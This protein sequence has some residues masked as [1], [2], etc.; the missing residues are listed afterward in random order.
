[1]SKLSLLRF[2]L[3]ALLTMAA[4]FANAADPILKV[5]LLGTGG[6][7]YSERMGYS[8]LIEV[9]GQ[10]LLFDVGRGSTQRLY[11]SR[12]NPKDV[13]AVF[14]THL[15]ND[16]YE[17]LPNLWLTPWFLLS[18]K[19][20]IELW[21]P[22]GS[23]EMVVGM[24]KMF[25]HDLD[26]RSNPI[27]KR[28]QLDITVHEITEGVVYER[29]DVKVTAF[30]VEHF[31][32]NPAF[33][34]R[35]DFRN[36][37]VVL[38]GDTTYNENVVKYGTGAD[39]LVHNVIAYADSLKTLPSFKPVTA[40]L[41]TPEQAAEVFNKTKPK[42]AAFSHIAK[43]GLSGAKGDKVILALTRKAGYEGPLLMG[44]DRTVIEIADTVKVLPPA[45]IADLPDLDR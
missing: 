36:H 16:H 37:S 35:V 18:R 43:K 6:P 8:T 5:T 41:T 42:L 17:G 31:D 29:Q 11:E 45:P 13:T 40:K 30:A 4:A 33:G 38:S 34:Y 26:H 21:G 19:E 7:E 24:R 10:K 44:R 2:V 27:F 25:Q 14:L 23:A 22:P 12:I 20:Q 1:M 3:G 9:N 39:L 15:H 28:E 32:G